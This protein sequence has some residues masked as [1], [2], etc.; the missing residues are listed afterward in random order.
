MPLIVPIDLTPKCDPTVFNIDLD[1]V[2]WNGNVP[3]ER[4]ENGVRNLGFIALVFR[5]QMHFQIPGDYHTPA[6]NRCAVMSEDA[7]P[8]RTLYRR[9]PGHL[10]LLYLSRTNIASPADSR[11][12]AVCVPISSGIGSE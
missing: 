6:P 8:Y 4:V 7:D 11:L 5:Q 3:R 9:P 1:L 12:I 2:F 10:A